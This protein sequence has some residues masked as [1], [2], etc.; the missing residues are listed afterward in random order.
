[1]SDSLDEATAQRHDILVAPFTL[2]LGNH[3]SKYPNQ[4][5]PGVPRTSLKPRIFF[6][7]GLHPKG[8]QT[9]KKRKKNGTITRQQYKNLT[10]GEIFFFIKDVRLL[11]LV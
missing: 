5:Q 10:A 3:S 9:E 7:V 4:L 2:N 1:M 8:Q 6:P 11:L